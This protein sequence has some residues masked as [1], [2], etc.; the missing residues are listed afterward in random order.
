MFYSV[1]LLLGEGG[2]AFLSLQVKGPQFPVSCLFLS[3]VYF[4][5]VGRLVLFLLT[6]LLKSS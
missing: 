6:F 5:P 3:L 2:V 1:H 4:F